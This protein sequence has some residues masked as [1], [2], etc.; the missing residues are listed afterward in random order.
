MVDSDLLTAAQAENARLI[1]MLDAY[2]IEWKLQPEPVP[3]SAANVRQ[4]AARLPGD[5]I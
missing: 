1:A 2:G 5:G 4:T 3:G